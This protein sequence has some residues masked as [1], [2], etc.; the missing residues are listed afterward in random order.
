M[1]KDPA[2]L[3]Y[4]KDWLTGTAG[5]MPEEKGVYVDLLSYQ[6]LDNGLPTDTVRLAKLVGIP[7]EQFLKIWEVVGGKFYEFEG[8]LHNKKLLKIIKIREE[9]GWKN[10]I[11]GNFAALLRLGKYTKKQYKL[12]KDQFDPND[13]IEC[14]PE[15]ITERLTEW[16]ELR[17]G[18]RSKSIGNG[19]N[20]KGSIL[21]EEYSKEVKEL[22]DNTVILFDE[23]T[24]PH[25]AKQIGDWHDTLDKCIRIDGYS[26]DRV[27]EIVKRMRMDDFWRTNFMSIMKLRQTNKQGVKYIDFFDARLK[28]STRP[29]FGI[30]Q[31]QRNYSTPQTSFS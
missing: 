13:F 17:L 10:T 14:E 5:M 15:R 12:L 9:K 19:N 21:K 1:E 18:E 23:R 25:T 29:A 7:H 4:S 27:R 2:F 28:G 3:W 16:I 31:V 20:N 11:I 24:R 26:A 30:P 6:H 22:Y 8:K